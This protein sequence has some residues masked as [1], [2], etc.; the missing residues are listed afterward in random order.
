MSEPH[1]APQPLPLQQPVHYGPAWHAVCSVP[2]AIEPRWLT[3]ILAVTSRQN[4]SVEAV[5]AQLGRPLDGT[6]TVTVRDG[7]ATIPLEGP[8]FRRAGLF[9]AISGGASVEDL[10]LDLTAALN[11]AAVSAILLNVDSPGGEVNGIA[12]LAAMIRAAE[13]QKPVVAY[14][15]DLG[16][17]AAYWLASAAQEVVVASTAL[18]GSIG[19]IATMPDPRRRGDG[20]IQF[21]SSQSP[22][23]APDPTTESGAD[24]LQ[25]MV[26]A[27]AA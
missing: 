15:S 27:L 21:V 16:A 7:V 11:E 12:E 10:G 17:S 4:L 18:V 8:I 14:I 22:R 20:E 6:R 24:Q 1:V 3:T 19:V 23:K 13:A 26:D 25:A 9:A 2:W 5:E